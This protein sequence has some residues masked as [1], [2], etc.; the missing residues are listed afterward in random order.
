[1]R[2]GEDVAIYQ[3]TDGGL[4]L[5]HQFSRV[6]L[7][8]AGL[9][10]LET[11]RG[12]D[13]ESG[14]PLLR[15]ERYRSSCALIGELARYLA[16]FG[17]RKNLLWISA[18][19]PPLGGNRKKD[20]RMPVY[21]DAMLS[22]LTGAGVAV[23]PVEVRTA[24]A[25]EPFER[26][27]PGSFSN[28][29]LRRRRVMN[30]ELSAA[31]EK[32]AAISGGKSIHNRSQLGEAMFD[33]MEETRFAYELRF[34]VPE[35]DWNGKVH[36][37]QVKVGIRDAQVQAPL[38]YTARSQ[39]GPAATDIFDS[40]A[41]GISVAPE[42]H[43]EGEAA[44]NMKVFLATRDLEWKRGNDGWTANVEINVAN[45]GKRA[46]LTLAAMDHD[47][48]ATQTVSTQIAVEPSVFA[49][50]FRLKVRDLESQQTGSLTVPERFVS[51]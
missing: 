39:S 41:I 25:Q 13:A 44:R 5:R 11:A 17:G 21:A 22:E 15:E 8:T 14:N 12:L 9:G 38:A 47:Q 20:E 7:D 45:T 29:P 42:T 19:F 37:L 23:Y 1:L 16:R 30:A 33:A 10:E 50:G 3:L 4:K 34:G 46:T 27:P 28:V 6:S 32:L 40:P 51:R 18:D 26:M 24:V 31:M 35:Q 48:L 49:K 2:S 36:L 43:E